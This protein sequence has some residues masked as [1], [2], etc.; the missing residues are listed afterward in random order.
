MGIGCMAWETQTGALYQPRLGR[1][2]GGSFKRVGIYVYL[3]LILL[4]FDRKQQNSVKL[5]SFDKKL[6][7]NKKRITLKNKVYFSSTLLLQIT[8]LTVSSC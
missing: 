2:M 1:E 5:L 3:W 4:R 8:F 7:T 6:K